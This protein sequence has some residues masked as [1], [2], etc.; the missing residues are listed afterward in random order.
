MLNSLNFSKGS[1]IT[2]LVKWIFF[3]ISYYLKCSRKGKWVW[4]CLKSETYPCSSSLW[5]II[6]PWRN[7][8]LVVLSLAAVCVCVGSVLHSCLT[9]IHL[10]GAVRTDTSKEQGKS[11]RSWGLW[12]IGS[13]APFNGDTLKGKN[14]PNRS[15]FGLLSEG[16]FTVRFLLFTLFSL[17]FMSLTSL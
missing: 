13:R 14:S 17:G 6:G 12:L 1:S 9:A 15:K 3:F 2:L 8:L 5:Q 7:W 4:K 16:K 10:A 11:A